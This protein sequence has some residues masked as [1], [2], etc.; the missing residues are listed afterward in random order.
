MISRKVQ[1]SDFSPKVVVTNIDIDRK[2]IPIKK[3]IEL[4]HKN[5]SIGLQFLAFDVR[6]PEKNAYAYKL[7]GCWSQKKQDTI[8]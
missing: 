1:T 3:H 7:E 6:S 8:L 2:N 4:T 5:K